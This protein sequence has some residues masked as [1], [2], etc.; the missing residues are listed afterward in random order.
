MKRKGFLSSPVNAGCEQLPLG[1]VKQKKSGFAAV[2][3]YLE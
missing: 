1:V 3:K 2:M